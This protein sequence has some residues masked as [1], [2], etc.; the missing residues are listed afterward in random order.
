MA[1]DPNRDV[2]PVREHSYVDTSRTSID[3]RDR[4]LVYK[5][6]RYE[7]E[8]KYLRLLEEVRS[9][10]KLSNCQEDKIKRLSTKLM[11]VT[12][13]PR[14]SNVALD[15]Y[16]DKNRIITLELENTKLKDKISVLRNQLLNHKIIGRSSSRSHNSQARQSSGRITCRSESSHYKIPSCHYITETGDDDDDEQNN[17]EKDEIFDAEKKEMASRIAEL[18]KE[19]SSY[20]VSNQ[21]AKVAENIEYIKVWRQMKLLN[22][23]LIAAEAANKSLNTQIADLKWKFE[24]ATKYSQPLSRFS[25][26][27]QCNYAPLNELCELCSVVVLK[28]YCFPILYM[29]HSVKVNMYLQN[30][31]RYTL[32]INVLSYEPAI[33][34]NDELATSLAV[35]RRRLTEMDVQ[36]LKTKESSFSLRE[37]DEQ[38]NDLMSEIKILQQ[39]NSELVDL[40][41]NRGEVDQENIE[42]KKK[43]SKQLRDEESLKNTFN[44]EQTNII[45]LQAANEQL[46]GKLQE[47]QKNIDTLTSFQ[48]QT[49]KQQASKSTQISRKQTDMKSPQTPYKVEPYKNASSQ[50]EKCRKCFETFEKILLLEECICEPRG[51]VSPMDKSVQTEFVTR[52]G[53]V[54]T[55]DQET[56]MTPLKEKRTEEEPVKELVKKNAE[57]MSTGNPLTPE[58]MLKLL[59]QAQINTSSDPMKFVPKNMTNR[60]AYNL[61]ELN[62]RHSDTEMLVQANQASQ[63]LQP[64]YHQQKSN[65]GTNPQ[66]TYQSL[67]NQFTDPNKILF[68]LFN[69]L[70]GYSQTHAG[71]NEATL[72]RRISTPDYQFAK[73]INNNAAK[74]SPSTKCTSTSLEFVAANKSDTSNA[75]RGGCSNRRSCLNPY[76]KLRPEKLR[77][78]IVWDPKKCN[79]VTKSDETNNCTCN[80]FIKCNINSNCNQQCCNNGSSK[81]IAQDPT[82]GASKSLK[83]TMDNSNVDQSPRGLNVTFQSRILQDGDGTKPRKA[84]EEQ[85]YSQE[86]NERLDDDKSLREYIV[87]LNKYK[88]VVN[89]SSSLSV[90]TECPDFNDVPETQRTASFCSLNCPNECIDALSSLSDPFPLVIPEGQGLLELHIMS[91]Q[92]STSAKQILFREKDIS[93]VQLFVSWDIWNQETTYTPTQKC[94][95]LNFNSS[96][97]YRI[98]DLSSF[99][100]Y[101]LM[102]VVIFQVNVYHE[103]KDSYTVARGKLCIKDILDYPQNKLHYIAPVNSVISC[104]LGMTFGQLSLWVRLSCD[105][106][107]VYKFKKTRGIVTEDHTVSVKS[108]VDSKKPTIEKPVRVG[109]PVGDDLTVLKDTDSNARLIYEPSKEIFSNYQNEEDLN[110]SSDTTDAPDNNNNNAG[111]TFTKIPL[112]VVKESEDEPHFHSS[113]ENA[114]Q[115]MKVEKS[116]K[117]DDKVKP[118][119]VDQKVDTSKKVLNRDFEESVM[120]VKAMGIGRTVAETDSGSHRSSVEEFNAVI[121]KSRGVVQEKQGDTTR[122]GSD[123]SISELTNVISEKNWEEYKQRSL[124]TFVNTFKPDNGTAETPSVAGLAN[125]GIRAS[126][127]VP[128]S[129]Q[130]DTD[131]IAID[132]LNMIL[133]PKSS[134]VQN[135]EIHLLYIEYSFLGYSGADM[136]TM[137][138]QKPR[139]PD[140]KLTYNFRRKFHV[141][142]ET[143]SK[144]NN[145]LRAMLG[146]TINPNIRFIVVSEPLPEETETK[147]CVEVGFANFN[148]KEYAFGESEKVVTI[149]VHSPD[150]SEQIGLLKIF[151]SGLD[152]IRQRLRRRESNL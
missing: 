14:I 16:D 115:A 121:S 107:K 126:I 29:F 122:E 39:H 138:V 125:D 76:T 42:L 131:T 75:L 77:R 144:Q 2:L 93:N 18:E 82:N 3:S 1:D 51:N 34:T 87:Q 118:A 41:S 26:M 49:E 69:I 139:P 62:Q 136:E 30:C 89:Q 15:V 66:N 27:H 17:L 101:V 128:L 120:S 103:D 141:D 100:N 92:L 48:T 28:I 52:S 109:M 151:V 10:K 70:Q 112:T 5:L 143:H 83:T 72:Y 6:D 9:L 60:V 79:Q 149:Q 95:K 25:L 99:F 106:E 56:V 7:L 21:R 47:L 67:E 124:L 132:I 104:S 116:T 40:T 58:K 13:S 147:E 53:I 108:P 90:Q 80:N 71:S 78:K 35:E 23:K 32:L 45:A 55:K 46:L 96:F 24:E 97:V 36:L 12:A 86:S 91:L 123:E 59:E 129:P 134:V 61:M 11:R 133:F 102:E 68:I 105:V 117:V 19:L 148:L 4:H 84:W 114:N 20:T 74:K 38:I 50:M 152:T 88:A 85:K 73:D 135:D 65:I 22:D 54:N 57:Q 43:V 146:D 81:S 113:F 31:S 119:K 142:E 130:H 127:S 140:T 111:K 145:M 8:D 37:K 98:S 110:E 63:V 44:S 94:P 33:R 64:R 137:S 150:G